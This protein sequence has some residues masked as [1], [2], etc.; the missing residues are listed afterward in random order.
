[1]GWRLSRI[2]LRIGDRGALEC[3]DLNRLAGLWVTDDETVFTA[4]DH[5]R[6][7]VLTTWRQGWHMLLMLRRLCL[8]CWFKSSVTLLS[9]FV[10]LLPAGCLDT[11]GERERE[12]PSSFKRFDR[13][14]PASL[15]S[16]VSIMAK[17]ICCSLL[18]YEHTWYMWLTDKSNFLIRSGFVLLRREFFYVCWFCFHCGFRSLTTLS[19]RGRKHGKWR[20]WPTIFI[21]LNWRS[22]VAC[23]LSFGSVSGNGRFGIVLTG[24]LEHVFRSDD[25]WL[26]SIKKIPDHASLRSYHFDT[27]QIRC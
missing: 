17:A 10:T 14:T 13:K 8:W 19:L 27:E 9:R 20:L 22:I 5:V 11:R 1:M 16:C 26:C 6:F 4:N 18:L 12:R 7:S 2:Y 3:L 25:Q 24:C 21:Y 23:C 15:E